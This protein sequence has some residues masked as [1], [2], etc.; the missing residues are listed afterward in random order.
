MADANLFP[1]EAGFTPRP[2]WQ[3]IEAARRQYLTGELTIPTTP[4]TKI[5][6][7]DGQ[8]YFAERSTDGTLPIRLMMEGVITREQ[9]Q[10]GMVI[11]NG[12][13]HVG[14]MF[15]ADPSIDR[16][17]GR[18]VCRTVHRRCDDRCCEHRRRRIRN[19]LV[20][21]APERHRPL[22]SAQRPGLRSPQRARGNPVD[23]HPFSARRVYRQAGG[24]A[25]E[26]VSRP[27]RS[28][29]RRSP[30]SERKSEQR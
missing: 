22:V 14:R 23:P 24:Q 11:V 30:K 15:D 1:D 13:E 12:I 29:R 7:S 16:G 17:F 19:G 5:F 4:A 18:A 25:G 9:M 3:V 21:T 8:V 10:R 27:A 26:G 6:L 28:R 20:S 2:A